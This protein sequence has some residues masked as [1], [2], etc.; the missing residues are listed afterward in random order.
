MRVY[1]Y[2]ILQADAQ[3]RIQGNFFIIIK[4]LDRANSYFPVLW[5]EILVSSGLL[6]LPA[7]LDLQNSSS[8][9]TWTLIPHLLHRMHLMEA[10][11]PWHGDTVHF[12]KIRAKRRPDDDFNNRK[13]EWVVFSCWNPKLLF[14]THYKSMFWKLNYKKVQN[15]YFHEFKCN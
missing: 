8:L 10:C 5:L 9:S 4:L 13:Q 6:S 3:R 2:K 11:V 14:V 12:Q 15:K 7:T 1:S